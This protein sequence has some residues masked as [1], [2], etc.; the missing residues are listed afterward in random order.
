ML[1]YHASTI[2]CSPILLALIMEGQEDLV[3]MF[4]LVLDSY[5]YWIIS[6][7]IQQNSPSRELPL[8]ESLRRMC[9]LQLCEQQDWPNGPSTM[10]LSEY[11]ERTI[12]EE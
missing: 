9:L 3:K 5:M 7:I 1:Q 8:C 10:P 2:P 4:T 11:L 6:N 12:P